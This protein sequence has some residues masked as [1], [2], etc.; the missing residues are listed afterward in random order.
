[1]PAGADA[2]CLAPAAGLVVAA[3]PVPGWQG[4]I[5]AVGLAVPAAAGAGDV[6]AVDGVPGAATVGE[7]GAAVPPEDGAP[8]V[9]AGPEVARV[10]AVARLPAVP[11][12]P[13]VFRLPVSAVGLAA[14][15]A[16]VPGCEPIAPDDGA[17]VP[18]CVPIA[19][20]AVPLV[21]EA[22]VAGCDPGVDAPRADGGTLAPAAGTQGIVVGTADGTAPGWPG[23]A[24]PLGGGAPGVRGCEV[25]AG[26]GGGVVWAGRFGV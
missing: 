2:G 13:A 3:G 16:A 22:T 17:A 5:A 12:V 20:D 19:R 4:C 6:A 9:E 10:P 15:G 25:W 7:E 18:G 8:V 26:A 21:P 23:I 1:M 11:R 24:V 14:A